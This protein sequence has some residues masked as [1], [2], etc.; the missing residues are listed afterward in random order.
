[1]H[2]F[3]IMHFKEHKFTDFLINVKFLLLLSLLFIQ[4]VF[5]LFVF[6]VCFLRQCMYL[7]TSMIPSFLFLIRCFKIKN[8]I[9]FLSFYVLYK[10][11][12]A[13]VNGI[14]NKHYCTVKDDRV[15]L[16]FW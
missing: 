16:K 8:E 14:L 11:R 15:E 10:I 2:I 3:Q 6:Y 5:F 1:M 13:K 12:K 4:G 9:N 7:I